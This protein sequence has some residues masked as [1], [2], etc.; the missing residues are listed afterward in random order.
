MT[1]YRGTPIDAVEFDRKDDRYRLLNSDGQIVAELKRHEYL[2]QPQLRTM[3]L[4]NG[5][6]RRPRAAVRGSPAGQSYFTI[7]QG[8]V[9]SWYSSG[10]SFIGADFAERKPIEN[11]GIRA[12]EVMARRCWR[13]VN[14]RLYSTY[15]REHEWIPGVPMTGDVRHEYGV[16]A[17]KEDDSLREYIF[18]N[19]IFDDINITLTDSGW[20]K[21]KRTPF[22]VG[23]IALWGEIVEHERGYRAEFAK[24]ASID[25]IEGA[26]DDPSLIDRLR[27][28][29]AV[30]PS[31]GKTP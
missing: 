7:S 8:A 1:L 5:K 31:D 26:K 22:A 17:F 23:S 15:R 24:I 16:H 9:F 11:A 27:G 10:V 29:Y 6:H 28:V 25:R 14:D 18:Q 19:R 4:S 12:G 21:A 20:A 2:S 13:V 3:R 30:S